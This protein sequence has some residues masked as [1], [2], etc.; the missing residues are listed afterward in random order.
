MFLPPKLVASTNRYVENGPEGR[1]PSFKA[2]TGPSVNGATL[3]Y[4]STS[5]PTLEAEF[6]RDVARNAM[7]AI[8][9][10]GN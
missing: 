9:A 3:R 8:S 1:T 7:K 10:A 4:S 6:R 5:A 2:D